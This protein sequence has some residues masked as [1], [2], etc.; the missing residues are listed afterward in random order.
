MSLVNSSDS[1]IQTFGREYLG[2]SNSNQE[3]VFEGGGLRIVW[4]KTDLKNENV[5]N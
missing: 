5:K 1:S 4:A 3:S 2:D